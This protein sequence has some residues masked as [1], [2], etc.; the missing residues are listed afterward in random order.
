MAE[1]EKVHQRV[2]QQ[3]KRDGKIRADAKKGKWQKATGA[4]MERP[5][6]LKTLVMG[7]SVVVC[8]LIWGALIAI[9]GRFAWEGRA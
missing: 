9:N 4:K 7:F 6:F 2:L 1:D 8:L 5:D 3:C